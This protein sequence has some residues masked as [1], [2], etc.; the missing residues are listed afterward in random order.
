MNERIILYI[1]ALRRSY[2]LIIVAAVVLGC[3]AY[4][5]A[6]SFGTTYEAHYSYVVSLSARDNS[7]DFRFDGYYALQATDV[8][9]ATLAG[10]A[11]TPEVIVAAVEQAGLL[12]IPQDA[13]TLQRLVQAEKT[14]PQLVQVTVRGNSAANAERLTNA[15]QTVMQKNIDGY[16]QQGIP[17]VQFRVVLSRVWLGQSQLQAGVIAISIFIIT[18]FLGMNGIIFFTALKHS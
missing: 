4:L 1:N 18:L 10:W 14:A 7:P 2:P 17:A 6:R 8:F 5:V 13:R 12:A 9:A 3:S 15:L 11:Q 16:Y